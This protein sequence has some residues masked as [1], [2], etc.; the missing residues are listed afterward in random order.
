MLRNNDHAYV[1][2]LHK[3]VK[4]LVWLPMYLAI[5][6]TLTVVAVIVTP[7]LFGS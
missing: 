1:R 5:F 4:V 6:V 3:S 2:I 7:P